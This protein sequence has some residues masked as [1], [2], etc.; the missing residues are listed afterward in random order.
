[1]NGHAWLTLAVVPGRPMI[2]RVGLPLM[3]LVVVA[4]AA[5]IPL[6]WPLR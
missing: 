1:M 6:V 3:L 5:I 2:A 4:A